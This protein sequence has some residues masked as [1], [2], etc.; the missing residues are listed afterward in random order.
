MACVRIKDGILTVGGKTLRIETNEGVVMFEDHP[1][2]GPMPVDRNGNGRNLAPDHSFWRRV[3]LWYEKGKKIGRT[4]FC[5]TSAEYAPRK[6]SERA[7]G[8]KR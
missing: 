6:E 4:G 1:Y 8:E 3:T 5:V 2:C 7:A